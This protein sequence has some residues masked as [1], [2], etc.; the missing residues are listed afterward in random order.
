MVF[1]ETSIVLNPKND[2]VVVLDL[3]YLQKLSALLKNTN[4]LTLGKYHQIKCLNKILY[5]IRK[6]CMVECVLVYCSSNSCK[7]SRFGI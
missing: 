4:I 7:V 5:L 1:K 3:L 6:V 2:T